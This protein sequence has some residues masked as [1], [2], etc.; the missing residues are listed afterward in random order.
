MKASSLKICLCTS[1]SGE[2]STVCIGHEEKEEEESVVRSIAYPSGGYSS[3]SPNNWQTF[4]AM[5]CPVGR[6]RTFLT[7]PLAPSPSFPRS[8]KSSERRTMDD[9]ALRSE[10]LLSLSLSS[11][12]EGGASATTRREMS[13]CRL[14][15]LLVRWAACWAE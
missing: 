2:V 5:M 8:S 6:C 12:E 4:L 1:G 10:P 15:W 3:P 7:S 13:S 14:L 11:S 9:T